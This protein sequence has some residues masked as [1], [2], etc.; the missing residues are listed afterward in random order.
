MIVRAETLKNK[1]IELGLTQEDACRVTGIKLSTWQKWEQDV[2]EVSDL[3]WEKA[4]TGLEAY[5]NEQLEKA[6]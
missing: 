1:R 5:R 6:L 3:L 4:N 2:N